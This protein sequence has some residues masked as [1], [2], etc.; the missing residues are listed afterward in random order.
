MKTCS[1]CGKEINEDDEQELHTMIITK[2]GDKIKEFECFHTD[3]W[4]NLYKDSLRG[5]L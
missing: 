2:R 3:C 5:K 1:V 4:K